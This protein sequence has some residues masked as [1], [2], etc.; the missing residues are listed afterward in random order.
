MKA[1]D[2][3]GEEIEVY[4]ADELTAKINEVKGEYEPKIKTL[5]TD[6]GSA[7]TA[8]ASRAHEFSQFRKLRDEDVAKLSEAERTIYENGLALNKAN[9]EK[10]EI[11]KKLIESRIETVIKAKTNGDENLS[12][13][14][15]DMWDLIG[16]EALS[17]A[18]MERKASM[19][20]GAVAQAE[21]DLIASLGGLSG[22]ALPP[23]M[24]D[25]KEESFA[26]TERGKSAA[27][28]LGLNLE[29]KK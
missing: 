2:K 19:A 10:A 25:K 29:N 27:K 15:R 17:D 26:D 12:K 13:K 18:D 22:G 14:V 5:E 23:K 21:P 11:E 20:L 7:K 8:L 3:D 16:L 1:F 6:L 24:E 28:E 9:E 4:S